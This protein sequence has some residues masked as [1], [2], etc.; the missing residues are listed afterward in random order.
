MINVGNKLFGML[1]KYSW[2]GLNSIAR[3]KIFRACDYRRNF[4]RSSCSW[5]LELFIRCSTF[6]SCGWRLPVN[7]K[8][9]EVLHTH[10]H[11][12][13]NG[14]VMCIVH[15]LFKRFSAETSWKFVFVFARTQ[16]FWTPTPIATQKRQQTTAWWTSLPHCT[17]CR[18]TLAHSAAMRA[19]SRWS[20]TARAR[21]AYT[22]WSHRMLY[23]R[24][25][26]I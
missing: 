3:K 20:A 5:A 8:F 22:S 21:H 4:P 6:A 23:R 12:Q 7:Q 15:A 9:K 14:A 25:S 1:C 17:G 16:V 18:R 13:K 24:V 19:A 2:L 26:G 11:I 10:T